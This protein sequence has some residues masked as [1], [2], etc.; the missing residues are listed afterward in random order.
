MGEG[1]KQPLGTY[2]IFFSKSCSKKYHSFHG[3]IPFQESSLKDDL[4]YTVSFAIML[5][6]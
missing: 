1:A 2:L 5:T 6:F 4:K 3:I